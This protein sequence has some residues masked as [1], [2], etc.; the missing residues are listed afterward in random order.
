[1]RLFNRREHLT[2]NSNIECSMN[3]NKVENDKKDL[4]IK[5][6]KKGAKYLYAG[7]LAYCLLAVGT[8]GLVVTI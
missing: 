8:G 1:M 5:R 3:T 4:W 7:F 6:A 2:E